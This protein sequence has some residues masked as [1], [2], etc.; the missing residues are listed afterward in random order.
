MSRPVCARLDGSALRHNFQL[1]RKLAPESK[2]LAVVKADAY[3]HGLEWVASQLLQADG[4]AVASIEEGIRLREAG[5]GEPVI[6]LSGFFSADELLL[7]TGYQ[8]T[9]VV[10]SP[11]QVDVLEARVDKRPIDVWLKF[12]SG[13][14]RLG[15]DE[16]QCASAY[17]RLQQLDHVR[18]AG[19][20]THFANAD[21][22]RDATTKEQIDSFARL[23]DRLGNGQASL[24]NSAGIVGWPQCH[25]DWVRPGIMLYGSS[26][27]LGKSADELGLEPVMYFESR[28]ISVS[29]RKAGDRIGYGGDWLCAE[30][31][32]VG[33]VAAGYG[34]G[35]PRH[36]P[37]GTPVAVKGVRVP[38]IG[39]VSMDLITV[40][41]SSV[42]DA[43]V[44]DPVE[45]WG[46]TVHVDEIAL[47]SNTI[48]YELMC[49]V[50][51]RV[52]RLPIAV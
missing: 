25:Q 10:H 39:R 49:H 9:P 8:L 15:F 30:D 37:P 47:L 11:W 7:L 6:M 19:L 43:T 34:D 22:P 35:Y 28:L 18:I 5:I 45:L 20:M 17:Q 42:A 13:M 50:T 29:Q 33:V 24:G 41:L 48:A 32:T 16:T 26:P 31:M 21:N 52:P 23:R 27:V 46:G 14:H 2:I 3:G 1:V 36:A 40:D 4:F 38:L 12:D 44:G 51:S